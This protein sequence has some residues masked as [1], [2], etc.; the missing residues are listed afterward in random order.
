[1]ARTTSSGAASETVEK[2]A[3]GRGANIALWV[4]QVVTAAVFLMAAFAK[5]TGDAQAVAT[6]EAIGFG[7]WFMYLIAGLETAGAVALLIPILSGLAGLAF[8]GLMIGAIV[9]GV[10]VFG[11]AGVAIPVVVLVLAAIIAWG[12]RGRTAEL[13]GLVRSRG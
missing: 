7:D 4:V 10:A 9:F 11:G 3:Q 6:F 2:T 12:R 8:V 5:F 13:V 1:M